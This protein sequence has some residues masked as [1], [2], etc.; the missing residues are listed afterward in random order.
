[1]C[2][3]I[4]TLYRPFLPLSLLAPLALFI[5]QVPTCEQRAHDKL[6]RLLWN[7]SVRFFSGITIIIIFLLALF[8][9]IFMMVRLDPLCT[10]QQQQIQMAKWLGL[11]VSFCAIGIVFVAVVATAAT[12]AAT[13]DSSSFLDDQMHRREKPVR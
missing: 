13:S 2:L 6:I 5:V 4:P 8:Y 9:C 11:I 12:T 10:Q 7:Y 3:L 1:M